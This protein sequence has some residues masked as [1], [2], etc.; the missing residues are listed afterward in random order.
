MAL[1]G[2]AYVCV[3]THSYTYIFLS[4]DGKSTRIS[5]GAPWE[6]RN[7]RLLV[8]FV[9]FQYFIGALFECTSNFY[10]RKFGEHKKM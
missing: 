1:S 3:H 10:C 9:Y 5:K 6:L 2:C 4:E 8:F 7:L